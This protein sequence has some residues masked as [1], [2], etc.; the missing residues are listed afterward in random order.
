MC[1]VRS[2]VSFGLRGFFGVVARRGAWRLALFFVAAGASES[3]EGRFIFSAVFVFLGTGVQWLND[4]NSFIVHRLV[5]KCFLA[6]RQ[7]SPTVI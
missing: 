3:C 2:L 4:F 5:R 1:A 6:L 7:T